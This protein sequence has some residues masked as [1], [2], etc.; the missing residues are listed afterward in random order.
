MNN[1][2]SIGQVARLNDLSIK[3]LRY[4]DDIGLFKPYFVDAYSG[5]RYYTAEQFKELDIILYL[6]KMGIPLKDIKKQLENRSLD[7]F[8]SILDSVRKITRDKIEVLKQI[9][10]GLISSVRELEN[11]KNN[12]SIG[13]PYIEQI[14]SHHIVEV[15][16]KFDSLKNMESEIRQLKKNNDLNFPYTIGNIGYIKILENKH[17]LY[18]GIFMLV[19]YKKNQKLDK[20]KIIDDGKFAVIRYK[21]HSNTMNEKKNIDKL[22]R[23]AKVN[24]YRTEGPLYIRKIVDGVISNYADE[25]MKEIRIRIYPKVDI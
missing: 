11:S 21:E 20:I 13:K 18:D 10:I 3:T 2:F 14:K 5:Y 19:D 7:D 22:I 17:S 1:K 23:F 16:K 15:N 12:E 25:W 4:Y 9:E 24:N 8:I 6:K